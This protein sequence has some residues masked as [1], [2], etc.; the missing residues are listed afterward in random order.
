MVTDWISITRR[1][2]SGDVRAIRPSTP[3]VRRPALRS[4][5]CRTLTSVFDRL[6]SISFCKLRT[7]LRSPARVAAKIRCR[8]RRTSILGGTPI[9]SVPLQGRVL[10]SVHP[11]PARRQRLS[12]QL[13]PRFQ[14]L[15]LPFSSQTHLVHVSPLSRRATR[16]RIRPV[17]RHDHLEERS[18]CAVFPSP[19]GAPAFASWTI[20]FPLRNSAFLTVGLPAHRLDRNGVATFHTHETRSGWAPS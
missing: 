6:R 9:N 10:G 14:R 17:M 4:V 1:S 2:L 7:R 16:T 8:S 20:L 3:G 12:V 13:V 15:D 19:F 11:D 5:T 18:S